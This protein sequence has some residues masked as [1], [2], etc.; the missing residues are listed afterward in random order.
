MQAKTSKCK[1]KRANASQSEKQAKRSTK[2]VQRPHNK[3]TQAK[4]SKSK[5][6]LVAAPRNWPVRPSRDLFQ[7]LLPK[8]FFT[9]LYRL[10]YVLNVSHVERCYHSSSGALGDLSVRYVSSIRLTTL[11]SRHVKDLLP[12]TWSIIKGRI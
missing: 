7:T 11:D 2:Q 3:A 5:K 1:P 9:R 10:V 4:A 6:C 12:T 8:R